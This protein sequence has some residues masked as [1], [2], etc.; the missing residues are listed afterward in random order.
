MRVAYAAVSGL[1][2]WAGVE[3]TKKYC[4]YL[5]KKR[6]AG[7]VRS[8]QIITV[9]ATIVSIGVLYWPSLQRYDATCQQRKR[10]EA[11]QVE[12][13]TWRVL[14]IDKSCSTGMTSQHYA[15]TIT[16]EP[17]EKGKWKGELPYVR[18]ED[19]GGW[20]MPDRWRR[21]LSDDRPPFKIQLNGGDYGESV[22]EFD[23]NTDP[24]MCNHVRLVPINRSASPP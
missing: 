23:T 5:K 19:E 13:L 4:L 17:V 8:L 11:Q 10:A 1:T 9:C 20:P 3:L 21:F 22:G 2:A 7:F 16:F 15:V 12:S 18:F 14:A 24:F 6:L